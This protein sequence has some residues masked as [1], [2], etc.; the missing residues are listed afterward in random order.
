MV[1][2]PDYSFNIKRGAILNKIPE[3]I[4]IKIE[5]RKKKEKRVCVRNVTMF[6]GL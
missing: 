5:K 2:S 6:S 3:K 4:Q 1:L